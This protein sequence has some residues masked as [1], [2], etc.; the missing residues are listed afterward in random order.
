MVKDVGGR[1]IITKYHGSYG[2][3]GRP[4][5]NY[6]PPVKGLEKKKG[7]FVLIFNIFFILNGI[8]SI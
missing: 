1:R 8:I 2:K 5:K 7:K 4:P 3:R 6:V